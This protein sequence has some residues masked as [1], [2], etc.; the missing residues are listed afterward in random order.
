M[1]RRCVK[2]GETIEDTMPLGAGH[3]MMQCPSC[4]YTKIDTYGPTY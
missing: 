2:C 4:G 1:M 3:Y